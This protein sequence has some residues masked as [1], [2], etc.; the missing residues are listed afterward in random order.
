MKLSFVAERIVKLLNR[1]AKQAMVNLH[2]KGMNRLPT[3][4]FNEK[5]MEQLF[6]AL[7]Q[8]SIQAADGKERH[9]LVIEGSVKNEYIELRFEDDCGG[10]DEDD[11]KRIFEPFFTTKVAGEG[12]GLGLCIVQRVAERSGGEVRIDNR[13]GEGV[14]IIVTLGIG[15]ER[16]S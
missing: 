1:S 6:F 3:I 15:E 4:Y 9:N 11:V 10:V 2:I 12:T 14:T 7:V 16:P 8:N 13:P 5:E